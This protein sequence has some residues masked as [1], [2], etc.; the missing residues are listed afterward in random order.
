MVDDILYPYRT[1]ITNQRA[2]KRS[3]KTAMDEGQ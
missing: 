2:S 3:F 1:R